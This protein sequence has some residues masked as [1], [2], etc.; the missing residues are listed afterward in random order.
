MSDSDEPRVKNETITGPLANYVAQRM[1]QGM[2]RAER[3]NKEL[4]RRKLLSADTKSREAVDR[5]A[6]RLKEHAAS[7]GREI[8]S[9]QAHRVAADIAHSAERKRDG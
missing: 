6:G 7:Q 4:Q 2:N 9:E 5:L 3:E 8:S 1:Q